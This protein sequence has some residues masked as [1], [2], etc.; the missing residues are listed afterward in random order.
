MSDSQLEHIARRLEEEGQKALEFFAGLKEADWKQQVY[1][2]G[3]R[4]TV[5]H[6]LAHF[7]SAE[8][9]FLWLV[10]DVLGGGPGA[11]RETDIDAFNEREVARLSSL[12]TH[13][14]L[15]DFR[16][17]RHAMLELV[18][19]MQPADLQRVGYHPWFGQTELAKM[20]KLVYRHNMVHL[21]DARKALKLGQP[22]PP[23]E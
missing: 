15:E 5:R 18:R 16:T 23:G 21:R 11:T 17:A 14:L 4:W 22:V 10:R 9:G 19:Q 13:R 1:S 2:T 3:S 7:V 12:S 20:L 6:I 8:R